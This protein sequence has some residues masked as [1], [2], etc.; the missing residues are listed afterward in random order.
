M[1]SRVTC[2]A[3]H[4]PMLSGHPCV[5]CGPIPGRVRVV[6]PD[7]RTGPSGDNPVDSRTARIDE[8]WE[9]RTWLTLLIAVVPMT[10]AAALVVPDSPTP[11]GDVIARC[12]C[13]LLLLGAQAVVVDS[14]LGGRR[15]V[16]VVVL[17][18]IADLTPGQPSKAQIGWSALNA[19]LMFAGLQ[20]IWW[21]GYQLWRDRAPSA[22]RTPRTAVRQPDLRL[23]G[24]DHRHVGGVA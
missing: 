10:I 13:R 1:P 20:F 18:M 24:S 17:Q 11:V 9:P 19:V 5:N 22:P 6:G 14:L 3:C 21:S 15:F 2:P 12:F 4:A 16:L 23:A 7:R 8:P